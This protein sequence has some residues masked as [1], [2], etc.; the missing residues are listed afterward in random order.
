MKIVRIAGKY[1]GTLRLKGGGGHFAYG[2]TRAEV[3]DKLVSLYW[4]YKIFN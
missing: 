2:K 1:V 4:Q 3:V